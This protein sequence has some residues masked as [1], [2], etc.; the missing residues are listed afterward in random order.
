MIRKIFVSE[1]DQSNLSKLKIVEETSSDISDYSNAVVLKPWGYEYLMFENES[2]AIWI[3]HLEK[4]HENSLHCHP[5]K[6]TSMVVLNGRIQVS[7]LKE[8]FELNRLDSVIYE[9]GVFHTQKALTDHV[10]LMEIETPPNKKDLVRLKDAYGRVGKGY[11]GSDKIAKELHLFEY[12]CFD[13]KDVRVGAKKRIKNVTISIKKHSPES[14]SRKNDN[15]NK[16]FCV[17]EGKDLNV[18][19][20]I[21]D[22]AVQISNNLLLLTIGLG[23]I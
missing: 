21:D 22:Q 8:W 10:F 19:N 1:V 9:E 14:F 20:V 5:R 2:L 7:T 15:K 6:K 11:E 3:L 23:N 16:L 17:L 18:G 4:G 13:K 12:V